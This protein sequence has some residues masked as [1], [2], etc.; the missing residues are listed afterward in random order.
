MK[1]L[2]VRVGTTEFYEVRAKR[3]HGQRVII[4]SIT[5]FHGGNNGTLVRFEELRPE[6]RTKI[7][8]ALQD[9]FTSS[10]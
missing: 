7:I 9:E 8:R 10:E 6:V 3:D 1:T 5:L 4:C 2:H